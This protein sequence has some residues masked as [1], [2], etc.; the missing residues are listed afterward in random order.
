MVGFDYERKIIGNDV[1]FNGFS[2]IA[3]K[4]KDAELILTL[5]NDFA[6]EWEK[7]NND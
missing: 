6:T 1:V 7:E 2:A 4:L 3:N 5:C